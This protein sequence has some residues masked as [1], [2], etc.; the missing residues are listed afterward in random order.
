MEPLKE[1]FNAAYFKRLAA[2][3]KS[4]YPAF[5]ADEFF[6]HVTGNLEALSLNERMRA[7][8]NV[9]HLYLPSTYNKAL[10]ILLDAAPK[11][12]GGYTALV[13][14]DFVAQY[15]L[16]D[17]KR[18]LKALEFFT[19]LG[20]SEFGIR[21]FLKKDFDACMPNLLQWSQHKNEHVRR[22]SSE[23][24]RP[25]LPWSFKLDRVIEEPQTTAKIL[26][27][28]NTD[29]S[30]YVRKSVANHLNDISKDNSAYLLNELGSWSQEHVHTAWI[31]KHATRTLVKK[32]DA[33]TLALLKYEKKVAG[34]IRNLKMPKTIRLGEKLNFE[35][36]L[37]STKNKNQK[38]V[39]DYRLHYQKQNGLISAKVFKLKNCELKPKESLLIKGSQTIKDFSTRKH[40]PGLHK[41]EFLVNGNVMAQAEFNLRMK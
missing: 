8:S 13:F 7:T 14:P 23:G 39:V 35:F 16:H 34:G 26:R 11:A 17:F 1:M 33:G 19:T 28:L 6:K 18:S 41:V 5:K 29:D 31:I 27:Q 21:E 10:D 40:Y 30:L 3:I 15:G 24:S 37:Y 9:L 20:S 4:V 22:L 36:E 25:R 38:L 2:A 12:P 32:G